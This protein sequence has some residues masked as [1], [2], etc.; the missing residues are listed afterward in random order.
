MTSAVRFLRRGALRRDC[1][2]QLSSSESSTCAACW[3]FQDSMRLTNLAARASAKTRAQGPTLEVPHSAFPTGKL[4]FPWQCAGWS[5]R[6]LWSEGIQPQWR[7]P[8]GKHPPT[9]CKPSHPALLLLCVFLNSTYSKNWEGARIPL[10]GDN[11][12]PS[13]PFH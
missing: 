10:R 1:P 2:G 8:R 13:L 7:F 11:L 9:V 6:P 12:T 5:S 3:I 4:R